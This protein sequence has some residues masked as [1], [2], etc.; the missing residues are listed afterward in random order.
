M[1]AWDEPQVLFA[2]RCSRDVKNATDQSRSVFPVGVSS[3]EKI[4]DSGMYESKIVLVLVDW[5]NLNL[6]FSNWIISLISL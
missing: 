5:Q 1:N 3:G 4:Y 6:D 2:Y